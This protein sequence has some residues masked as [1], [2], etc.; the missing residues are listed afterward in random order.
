MTDWRK[1][2]RR[3]LTDLNLPPTRE[4]EIVEE[5]AQHVEDRYQD[6]LAD[7]LPEAEASR[8]ALAEMSESNLLVDDL[9]VVERPVVRRPVPLGADRGSGITAGVW[10]DLRY[11]LRML[12]KEYRIT[13]VVVITMAL[14]IGANT[15]IFSTLELLVF[16]PFAFANQHRLLTLWEYQPEAGIRRGP[17]AAGNFNDWREQNHTFEQ[18][19]ATSSGYFDLSEGGQPERLSGNRVTTG[20]FDLLGA[21]AALGRTFAEEEHQAGRDRVVV[22]KHSL[23]QSRFGADPGVVGRVINLN[24]QSFTVIGVMPKG[25]DFPVGAGELWVPLVFSTQERA[26]RA[27]HYLKVIGL[28]RLGVT[29]QQVNEDLG[30]IA[31]RAQHAYSATNRGRSVRVVSLIEDA[32]R[33]ARVGAPFM[34]ISALLVLLLACANVANLLLARAAS[35]QQEIAIRLALGASRYRVIRQL[36]AESLLLASLGGALGLLFSSWS[37][38]AIKGVPQDFSR[39]IPGWEQI[40]IDQVALVFTVVLSVMTGLLSGLIPAFV[41]TK[42]NLTAAL[43]EGGRGVFGTGPHR[44]RS[45]LVISEVA[46]SLVLLAGAGVMLRS[47]VKLLQADFGIN[48]TNV[49]TMQVSLT[50]E[51]YAN[52]QARISFYETLLSRLAASPGFVNVGAVETLPLGYTYK[53]RECLSIGNRTFPQNQRPS[54]AWRVATPGYFEAIGTGLRQGR[55]FS[56]RD[57]AG[58]PRVALVNEAF[59]KQFLPD[60]QVLG[61]HLKCDEAGPHEII[62]I[63]ANVINEDLE[64]RHEPE[65]YVPYAQ[66]AERTVYLVIRADSN[67]AA[68]VADVRREVGALDREAPVFNVKLMEQLI[69]ERLSPK[70]M[71]VYALGGGALIALLLAAVGIYSVISYTVK[72]QTHEIGLRLALG[73][74]PWHILKLVVGEGM[75]LV[76]I[77]ILIGL[78][79]AW[80]LTRL[81]AGLLFGV[82]AHDPATLVAIVLLLA[83]A[84][85][86]A[87]YI[88][89][90]RATKVDPMVA[91]RGNASQL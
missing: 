86:A 36:L 42:V 55:G 62:G 80:V 6:L 77:G 54:I 87:C 60:Q 28:P 69:D 41:G 31:Q 73:A 35:R 65:V 46:L 13:M 52:N 5:L 72:K 53:S 91:L 82:G 49:L 19:V 3:W 59:A 20:F 64:E 11:G 30:A 18:L 2:I 24:G 75:K 9:R 4:A 70:R 16:R 12:I 63:V 26:D 22:L 8:Q 50:G 89:A 81:M 34:F 68:L 58:A 45:L 44:T 79:A 40:G 10:N 39:L 15:T 85:L 71:A 43:N 17:V 56:Q 90:R 14:G 21:K 88:P 37:I 38:N 47:F 27:N 25:F 57:N 61:Q 74:Q 1:E 67:P 76:L 51:R 29:T 83:S 23:W 78:V 7:G 84:A 32:T 48:P 66:A 33:G